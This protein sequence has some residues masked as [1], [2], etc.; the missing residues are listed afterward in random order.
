MKSFLTTL[1]LSF[2]SLSLNVKAGFPEGENGF[3]IKK[4]E[5]NYRLPCKEIGKDKCIAR[6]IGISACTF[7]YGIESNQSFQESL[8]NTDLI[9]RAI[10]KGN[11]LDV[12]SIFD[13]NNSIKKP[14]KDEAIK[15]IKYCRENIKKVIPKITNLPEEEFNEK[16]IEELT[17]TYP[18][19]YLYTLEEIRMGK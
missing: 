6:S 17:D 11:N 2:L 10:M 5:N 18:E 1:V 4:I 19:W 12:N 14:I 7:V 3:D 13:K 9:F 16:R 15:T 8:R